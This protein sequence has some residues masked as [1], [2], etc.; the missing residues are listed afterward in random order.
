MIVID[1]REPD[2][3]R[4]LIEDEA[5][6]D[7]EIEDD[8]NVQDVLQARVE[9]E[10]DVEIDQ[11]HLPT[12]DFLVGDYIIERKQY[13]DFIGRINQS[14]RD[15]WQQMLATQNAAD[16][17]GYKPTLLFEGEWQGALNWTNMTPKEPTMAIGSLMKMGIQTVH[18]MGPRATAQLLVKLDDGT[19]HDIGSIRDTP[20]V[21][22]ELIP[23]YLTEGFPGV[24]PS[25]AED[26]LD[27]YGDF[28]TVVNVAVE[29]PEDLQEISGIGDATAEKISRYV[30]ASLP[31]D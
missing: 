2:D 22:E 19:S 31:D 8:K 10:P 29:N 30:T 15:I 21:P 24:G 27:R 7:V 23:R 26:I 18:V 3:L 16:E 14:E 9:Q 12:A 6:H 20:S 11:E 5:T 17:L 25:R 1:S 13:G 4:R 28:A